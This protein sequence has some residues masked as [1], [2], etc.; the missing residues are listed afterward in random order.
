MMKENDFNSTHIASFVLKSDGTITVS[1]EQMEDFFSVIRD[2]EYILNAQI[3]EKDIY[4]NI[5]SIITYVH[6][7]NSADNIVETDGG[8]VEYVYTTYRVKNDEY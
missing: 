4:I 2:A 6:K 5:D 3:K 7:L 1:V 8:Q